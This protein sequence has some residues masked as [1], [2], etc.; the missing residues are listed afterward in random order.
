[1]KDFN[2]RMYL[3]KI[4]KNTAREWDESEELMFHEM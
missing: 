1:M 3:G 4:N 2:S